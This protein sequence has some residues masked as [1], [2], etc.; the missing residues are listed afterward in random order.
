MAEGIT[1]ADEANVSNFIVEALRF[2]LDRDNDQYGRWSESM[3][4]KIGEFLLCMNDYKDDLPPELAA[5][6]P[7]TL[8]QYFKLI[9]NWMRFDAL[10]TRLGHDLTGQLPDDVLAVVEPHLNL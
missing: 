8:R 7:E 9:P 10:S 4:R 5:A 6:Y 3:T 1:H 2:G